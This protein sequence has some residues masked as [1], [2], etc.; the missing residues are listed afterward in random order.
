M[1]ISVTAWIFTSEHGRNIFMKKE[2]ETVA[3][4]LEIEVTDEVK[5]PVSPAPKKKT[6]KKS[7]AKKSAS[8]KSEEK[9]SSETKAEEKKQAE[10]VPADVVFDDADS[11]LISDDYTDD[12]DT[13]AAESVQN[14]KGTLTTEM[15]DKLVEYGRAHNSVL[16]INDINS[17]FKCKT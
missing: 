15:L 5:E 11:G 17:F 3:P 1:R 2:N 13:L 14:D 6:A 12:A 4:E 8:E 7:A 16:E 9:K 10:K